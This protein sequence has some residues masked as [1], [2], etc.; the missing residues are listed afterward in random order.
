ML[1]GSLATPEFASIDRV[2]TPFRRSD[3]WA[4]AFGAVFLLPHLWALV[5]PYEEFPYSSAPM[6]AHYVSDATPRYRLRFMGE[7]SSGAGAPPT[8]REIPPAALGVQGVPFAR[9]FFGHVYGSI[10]RVSP[11][12]LHGADAPAAFEA[13][14]SDFVGRMVAV[15]RRGGGGAVWRDLSGVRLEAVRLTADN[16]DDA[17]HVVGRYSPATRRFTRT[18]GQ[19]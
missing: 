9:Y 17:V 8:S 19:Q 14:L 4:Y 13:R 2:A 18:W 10:D 3:L 12:G 15:L 7:F 16:G 5:A 6:F 1:R 11:F